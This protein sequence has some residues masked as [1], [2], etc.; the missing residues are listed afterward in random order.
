MAQSKPLSQCKTT[1]DSLDSNSADEVQIG[2]FTT[3]PAWDGTAGVEVSGGGYARQPVT[4][5]ADSPADCS[6]GYIQTYLKNKIVFG[7]ATSSWGTVVGVGIWLKNAHYP[8]GTFAF[9]LNYISDQTPSQVVNSGGTYEL[10]AGPYLLLREYG[11][12]HFGDA[13]IYS[14]TSAAEQS[15]F[16]VENPAWLG[17]YTTKPTC[18]SP[19]GIECNV[20]GYNRK[21]VVFD[22][23]TLS[24]D[25]KYTIWTNAYDVVFG[26]LELPSGGGAIAVTPVLF[27]TDDETIAYVNDT[28]VVPIISV[29]NFY[30]L[31]FP[32]GTI[33]VWEG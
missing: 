1:L 12:C 8:N 23:G 6:K 10:A 33:K 16:S 28:D 9:Q 18:M 15:W 2:L 29:P 17:L 5:T 3:F 21:P 14:K 20:G 24:S 19:L 4:W 30:V 22:A 31:R 25:K 27:Q 11:C 32:A 7:P 26:P 13:I